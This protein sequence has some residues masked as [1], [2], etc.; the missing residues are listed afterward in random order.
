MPED[1]DSSDD[2]YRRSGGVMSLQSDPFI[3]TPDLR[4]VSH[5]GSR[6]FFES[7]NQLDALDTDGDEDLY[8]LKD[9]VVYLMSTGPNSWPAAPVVFQPIA[10]TPDGAAPLLPDL[11]PADGQ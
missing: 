4:A 10:A 6:L 9:G 7:V 8:A 11:R 3:G 5:D 1:T 2:L